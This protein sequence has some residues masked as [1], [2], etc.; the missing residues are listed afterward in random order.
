MENIVGGS[1][2]N[3]GQRGSVLITVMILSVLMMAICVA[4]YDY[5]KVSCLNNEVTYGDAKLYIAAESALAVIE[6]KIVDD[7]ANSRIPPTIF[8]ANTEVNL[9]DAYSGQLDEIHYDNVTISKLTAKSIS[10]DMT[11]A[12]TGEKTKIPGYVLSVTAEMP[13]PTD[14]D[15]VFTK[16]I[17]RTMTIAKTPL[18]QY[19]AF[20]DT[21]FEVTAGANMNIKGRMHCNKD[22]YICPDGSLMYI[23]SDYVRCA[24]SMYHMRK[25]EYNLG[26]WDGTVFMKKK[27]LPGYDASGNRI[28]ANWSRFDNYLQA[29]GTYSGYDSN[30]N[31]D[32]LDAH[33][34]E[35]EQ[36]DLPSPWETGSQEMWEGT[37]KT[38]D[39]GV[40][41]WVP[42]DVDSKD[43]LRDFD[44]ALDEGRERYDANGKPDPAGDYTSGGEFHE[45]AMQSSSD[46][47]AGGLCIIRG[48][49]GNVRYW[50]DGVEIPSSDPRVAGLVT[51]KTTYDKREGGSV[52]ILEVD[53]DVL[54]HGALKNK[55]G[56]ADD[57]ANRESSLW[58]INGMFYVAD[59]TARPTEYDGSGNMVSEPD[60]NGIRLV[61]GSQLKR[62]SDAELASDPKKE[63][64]LMMVTQNPVYILG[65]FNV[66]A[67]ESA[68]ITASN[69]EKYE[70]GTNPDGS[71]LVDVNGNAAKKIP[72]A[73]FADSVNLLSENFNKS[74]GS[75]DS[76]TY[77]A[78][79]DT[80]YNSAMA[81]GNQ[82]TGV[83]NSDT[84]EIDSAVHAGRDGYGGGLE[85]LP[86]F[87]EN[88]GSKNCFVRGSFVV[89]WRSKYARGKW[90]D[91]RYSPPKRD[92]DFET[93]F[94]SELPPHTPMG[95][96]VGQRVQWE[97]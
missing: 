13:S 26:R 35:E 47:A 17:K 8:T 27:G 65:D 1:G 34:S 2:N 95:R 86:R 67:P 15:A 81:V 48:V 54:S 25:D 46:G 74:G 80:F 50:H 73:I 33:Y 70:S 84:G 9:Y 66:G 92:W 11:D 71:A 39:H 53:M 42:P 59:R 63:R 3:A 40:S 22:M 6:E 64:G 82:T 83:L 19:F 96:T 57:P 24:G 89:L 52:P 44:P 7:T 94:E 97:E 32:Y 68:D 77:G 36:A 62:Y 91:A 5:A 79:S 85:N 23:N 93:L 49:D 58:P 21:D 37:A 60:P 56:S 76:G 38:I 43:A 20:Y 45:I 28:D 18:F 29:P 55:H 90:S 88:W 75:N 69:R 41:E 78:A 72:A 31:Q 4:F 51:I 12:F 87:H 10:L 14:K 16:T 61:N 30:Y